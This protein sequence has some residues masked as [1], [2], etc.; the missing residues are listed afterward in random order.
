MSGEKIEIVW[1]PSA[2]EDLKKLIQYIKKT[3]YKTLKKLKPKS[4]L[5][6]LSF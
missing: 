3:H 4:F 6:Y 5:K 1:L 2:K